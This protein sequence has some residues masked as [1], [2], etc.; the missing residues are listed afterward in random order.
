MNT[1]NTPDTERLESGG[2]CLQSNAIASDNIFQ[3]IMMFQKEYLSSTENIQQ[4]INR[5]FT[6]LQNVNANAGEVASLVGNSSEVIRKNA[7]ESRLSA[8]SM[9]EA[10]DSAGKLNKG[11]QDIITVFSDLSRYIQDISEKISAIEDIADLTNLL[12][13]N[14]AIEA[15][16]AGEQGRG[17]QVVAK[18]VRKLAD[19]S[20][21]GADDITSILSQLTGRLRAADTFME[22]Y[23]RLQ[24]DVLD[25]IGTSSERLAGTSTDLGSIVR[26]ITSINTLVE[27]QATS[28]ASLLESLDTVHRSSVETIA[29][30]PYIDAAVK[31]FEEISRKS[32][33]ELT[34]FNR[35][36]EGLKKKGRNEEVGSEQILRVGH[37]IAYPPW[38]SV[39]DCGAQGIS[40]EN[41]RNLLSGTGTSPFFVGGQ[42]GDIYP[43]LLSGELDM[44]LNVGWP[45]QFFADQPV[46]ASD[47]YEKFRVRLF[48][49]EG[50]DPGRQIQ[51]VAVQRGS[52][53]EEIAVREGY[54][55]VVFENDIQGMVQLLWNNVD[56]L[57]TED[58]VGRY[59]SETYFLGKME[60][61][62]RVLAEL[63][64]V[65]LFRDE[66]SLMKSEFNRMISERD[67]AVPEPS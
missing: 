61:T 44:L 15:A 13:L 67:A 7:E 37:D 58:R 35:I 29:K 19:R 40:I 59:I 11:F 49:P 36:L 54:E 23:N 25:R 30:V 26:E 51:K 28:T 39:E 46:I 56:A 9:S 18:E 4:L 12:A 41:T 6:D 10:A 52:F 57:A 65:Y 53:S 21:T 43:K 48:I 1:P 33:G 17:F 66:A 63:D 60:A 31:S 32:K 24:S 16:R 64:V 14:A 34:G 62:G 20:K 8:E 22:E 3:I 2:Q 45:N 47:A 42:W 55:P 50:V 5:A 27:G 38:T